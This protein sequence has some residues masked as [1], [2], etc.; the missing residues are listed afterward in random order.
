MRGTRC[1]YRN[2]NDPNNRNNNIGFRVVASHDSCGANTL[3][4]D[5]PV[6]NAVHSWMTAG[7][8]K[9]NSVFNLADLSP[10]GRKSGNIEEPRS[11][12]CLI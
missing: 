10:K 8:N 4:P 12:L 1:A 2:N 9:R 11:D 6:G 7:Q 3:L 5:C